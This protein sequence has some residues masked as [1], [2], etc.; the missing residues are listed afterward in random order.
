VLDQLTGD[1]RVEPSPQLQVLR[2]GDRRR[3]V[4]VLPQEVHFG[5]DEVHSGHVRE[6]PVQPAVQPVR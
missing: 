5:L 6:L 1:N 2:V 3:R 4:T